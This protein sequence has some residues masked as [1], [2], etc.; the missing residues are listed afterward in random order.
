MR[1]FAI[2]AAAATMLFAAP[3]FAQTSGEG[4]LEVRGGIAWAGGA[5]EAFAGV[6][7]GY[8][9]DLG[10]K[11][12]LGLEAG[13]DKVLVSGSNVFFTGAARAGAKLGENG[14]L[15]VLGGYGF[16]EG[17]GDGAFAGAGYQHKFGQKFYGKIEYR[18]TLVSGTDVNF[19]GIGLGLAF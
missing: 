2:A 3:A 17:G 15:Y 10:D 4:R 12:F 1:K 6:A 5:D 18:R 7:A 13:A 8:D 14:K 9:F 19:A 11:A 16:V